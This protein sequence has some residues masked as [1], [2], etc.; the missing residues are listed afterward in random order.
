MITSYAILFLSWPV[1]SSCFS[2]YVHQDSTT[3]KRFQT[4]IKS[5]FLN[6]DDVTLPSYVYEKIQTGQIAVVPNFLNSDEVKLLREDAKSLHSDGHFSTDA[7]ASYGSTG[8][9][10]PSKDRAVLKLDRWRNKKLGNWELRKMFGQKMAR[11]RAQLSEN[12]GRPKLDSG[13]SVSDYGYGS[14]EISYTRFGPGAFLKRHIDEHHEELKGKDGWSKPTRRSVTWLIYLN[15]DWDAEK[16]GGQLRVFERRVM[17]STNVGAKSNGDLQIGWLRA[18]ETDP[19]ERPVFLDGHCK[20]GKSSET[21]GNC[22]MYIEDPNDGTKLQYV[23]STFF[24]SPI[25]FMSGSE[26]VTKQLLIK[27]PD[28]A[29]RF[30]YLEA[31]KSALDALFQQEDKGE[32][33]LPGFD[34]IAKL[35]EPSGGTL[36]VFDSV[37]VPHEV[38]ATRDRE[39]WATSGWFHEDQQNIPMHMIEEIDVSL[40]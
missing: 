33:S 27:R 38:L 6:S 4:E 8:K 13:H 17:P 9:F 24:A 11:V 5:N 1:A 28:L 39:R 25:F 30:H 10:D 29:S 20:G 12:L 31:P 22:A 15:E 32:G 2:F 21:T 7:L 26:L 37:S 16:H 18:T 14:T 3:L 19:V 40:T 35:I 36:V 34:E 23:T